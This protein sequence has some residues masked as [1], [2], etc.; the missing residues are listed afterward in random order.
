MNINVYGALLNVGS[1]FFDAR[2][3]Q[4]TTLTGRCID[5]HMAAQVN[6]F[7]A[8]EYDYKGDAV[9]YCV[10]GSTEL[11]INDNVESIANLYN[12]IHTTSKNGIKFLYDRDIFVLSLN[13]KTENREYKQVTAVSK[14][15]TK[16][17]MYKVWA[18]DQ[19]YIIL[20]EDHKFVIK[21]NEKIVEAT[22]KELKSDDIFIQLDGYTSNKMLI[23]YLGEYE[24]DVYDITVQDNHNFFGNNILTHNCDTDSS[25]F[26]AYPILKEQIEN[27]EIK[28]DKET[29]AEFYDAICEET[30][31]TFPKYMKE[32]H[33]S[34]DNFNH[35][36]AAGR[37]IVGSTALYITKKRYAIMVYDDEGNRVDTGNKPGKLKAMGLDL[38]R[39]DTPIYMQEFLKE[40]LNLLLIGAQKEEIINRIKEFREEFRNMK[41][42]EKGTPKRVNKLQYYYSLEYRINRQGHEEF[43]KKANMPGHVR[44]AINYN[45]LLKLYDDKYSMRI[46]DGMKT[47]VCK[48]KD[49]PLGITSIGIPT[50]EKRIPEW[51]KELPFDENE[52]EETIVTKKI[53]NL[54]GVMGWD[55]DSTKNNT[56]FDSLFDVL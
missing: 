32:N 14:Q 47:I 13:P 54:L 53:E 50:D 9:I 33:N 34:P 11:H 23:E 16:K 1:R 39:S 12:R 3:G 26:S 8:G 17:K 6:E 35:T 31:K 2:L 5:K 10:D 56:T 48:L 27:G 24:T 28:W 18:D 45:R 37:E 36:I 49:N 7:I 51:F 40:I 55:L 38:K 21:R 19:N 41:P 44:A 42:W 46:V 20:S 22:V 25:Y 30:N 4:S 43:I 15:T 52:M 29:A